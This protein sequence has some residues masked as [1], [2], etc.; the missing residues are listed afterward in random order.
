MNPDFIPV[1]AP[2][3]AG[4]RLFELQLALGRPKEAAAA[5]VAAAHAR[6]HAGDYQVQTLL[7]HCGVPDGAS[8][9]LRVLWT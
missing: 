5:V 2:A 9:R 4:Q 3:E 6:Q 7:H 8:S 1:M